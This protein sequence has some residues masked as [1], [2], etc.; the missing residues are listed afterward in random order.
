ML[1]EVYSINEKYK[2]E[3]DVAGEKLDV[4]DC[5]YNDKQITADLMYERIY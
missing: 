1:F 2:T 3:L 4:R 5:N